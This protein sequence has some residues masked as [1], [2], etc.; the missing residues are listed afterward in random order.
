MNSRFLT[1]IICLLA[2][3]SG[4]AI[5]QTEF[6]PE[7]PVLT[8]DLVP[9]DA[10][11]KGTYVQ[12]ELRLTLRLRGRYA[13]EALAITLPEIPDAEIITIQRPRTRFLVSY[14]GA[15]H[16]YEA[17]Y[18]IIPQR[19]G[20]LEI[21]PIRIVGRVRTDKGED[22]NFDVANDGFKVQADPAVEGFSGEQ[23]FVSDELEIADSWSHAF[24]DIRVGDVVRREVHIKAR[25]SSGDRMPPLAMPRAVGA[26]LIDAGRATETEITG[27]GTIGH[28]WQSWDIR[29]DRETFAEIAPV[30]LPYWNATSHSEEIVS[31]PVT[32][33]EPLPSDTAAIAAS[34]MADVH[35]EHE[36]Q[37]VLWFELLIILAAPLILCTLWFIY[38]LLPTRRD[39]SFGKQLAS[40]PTPKD[41]IAAVEHWAVTQRLTSRSNPTGELC[42]QGNADLASALTNLNKSVFSSDTELKPARDL[43]KLCMSHAR[44][45]RLRAFRA[46]LQRPIDAVLGPKIY[47]RQT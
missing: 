41:Q 44:S 35:A 19:S 23:W 45:A 5:A 42:K 16:V 14:A 26:T 25:G 20:V 47:I 32:R 28:L 33:I 2:F 7:Q 43:A 46:K 18:A 10:L 22:L 36:L 30:R 27:N 40:A 39:L 37:R 12:A 21:P 13:Y 1:A 3:L 11:T 31:L 4:K 29:V 17:G 24:D 8:V 38:I 15:G 6:L 9:E 34:I